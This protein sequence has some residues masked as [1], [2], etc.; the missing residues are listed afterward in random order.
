MAGTQQDVSR[1]GGVVR[2]LLVAGYGSRRFMRKLLTH[3]L[4]KSA[5]KQALITIATGSRVALKL[6]TTSKDR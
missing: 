4:T 6:A 2:D 1:A 3:S 5:C